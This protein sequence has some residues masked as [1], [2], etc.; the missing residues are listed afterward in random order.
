MNFITLIV[1]QLSSQPNVPAFLLQFT[2]ATWG[3]RN[4]ES[5]GGRAEFKSSSSSLL[6]STPA[7][8]GKPDWSSDTGSAPRLYMYKAPRVL[9]A[10]AV[11][12]TFQI[13]QIC[14]GFLDQ[15]AVKRQDVWYPRME[16]KVCA[17]LLMKAIPCNLWFWIPPWCAFHHFY[18][19]KDVVSVASAGL[20]LRSVL[21]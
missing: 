15:V 5:Q 17:V 3:G 4:K 14:G 9:L 18:D 1:V 16:P 11:V 6:L 20:W 13:F 8:Q 2:E 10:D 12:L 21:V 7:P 19:E